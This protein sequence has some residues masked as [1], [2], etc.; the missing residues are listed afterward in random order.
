ME[1]TSYP[2]G[3]S[4][5]PTLSQDFVVQIVI[6]AG[7]AGLLQANIQVPNSIVAQGSSTLGSLSPRLSMPSSLSPQLGS[8]SPQSSLQRSLSGSPRQSIPSLL[9]GSSWSPPRSLQDDIRTMSNMNASFEAI[10]PIRPAGSPNMGLGSFSP[11]QQLGSYSPASSPLSPLGSPTSQQGLSSPGSMLP[12]LG[13]AQSSGIPQM[14]SSQMLQSLSPRQSLS[15]TG[16]SPSNLLMSSTSMLNQLGA[17]IQG[18]QTFGGLGSFSP[19][20][21]GSL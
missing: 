15:P 19:N 1:S 13:M 17:S 21:S 16:G 8:V 5:L 6:P 12:S 20:S 14:S 4:G 9:Q 18:S 3:I 7:Q 11:T 2:V 10:S